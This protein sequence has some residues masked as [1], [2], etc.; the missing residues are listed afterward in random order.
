[1][2]QGYNMNYST[3]MGNGIVHPSLTHFK[4]LDSFKGNLIHG[5]H[6]TALH[7]INHTVQYGKT[8]NETIKVNV[9]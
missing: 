3:I 4:L 1:M 5:V 8:E 9:I 7:W 6:L 2:L